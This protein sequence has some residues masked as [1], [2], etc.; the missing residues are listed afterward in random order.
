MPGFASGHFSSHLTIISFIINKLPY[1]W[2]C[3]ARLN[4]YSM[5]HRTAKTG[6]PLF[7]YC[8]QHLDLINE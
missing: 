8:L 1:N 3:H 5:T 2:Q 4:K 7:C 6:D